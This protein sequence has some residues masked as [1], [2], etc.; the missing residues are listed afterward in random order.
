M[1]FGKKRG[2]GTIRGSREDRTM[3]FA[4]KIFRGDDKK[5]SENELEC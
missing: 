2:E 1:F 4:K 3:A 5:V